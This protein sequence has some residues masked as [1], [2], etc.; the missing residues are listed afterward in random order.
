MDIG[1]KLFIIILI[2]A[3]IVIGLAVWLLT[4]PWSG[5]ESVET[6]PSSTNTPSGGEEG[7]ET[8]PTS[9]TSPTYVSTTS[10][11]TKPSLI[12]ISN[13]TTTPSTVDTKYVC[14]LDTIDPSITLNARRQDYDLVINVFIKIDKRG[15]MPVNITWITIDS[16]RE[17]QLNYP[18]LVDQFINTAV[19]PAPASYSWTITIPGE[20]PTLQ[21]KWMPG[22]EHVITISYT[23]DYN[24]YEV[25]C[26][27]T[28]N[29][30]VTG[31]G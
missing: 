6:S 13:T 29:I 7:F 1:S 17:Y 15:D 28:F 12:I 3:V 10:S 24:G 26:S 23:V 27:K 11:S 19:K 30:T 9:P 14:S 16:I 8:S 31:S 4:T 18:D 5:Q 20:Y 22:T 21:Q 25:S 2:V